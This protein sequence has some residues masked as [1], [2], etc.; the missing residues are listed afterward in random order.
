MILI[1]QS[2]LVFDP[3]TRELAHSYSRMDNFKKLH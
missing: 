1:I 3:E 2:Y